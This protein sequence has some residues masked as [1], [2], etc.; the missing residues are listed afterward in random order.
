MA[1][2]VNILL[3]TY[4]GIR[5]IDELMQSLL[6]QTHPNIKIFVRDDGSNDGTI[7]KLRDYE[8][9]YANF[10]VTQGPRFGAAG[11]FMKLLNEADPTSDFYAFCDQDDVWLPRKIG[12]AVAAMEEGEKSK[13]QLYFSRLEFVDSNL[14]HLGYSRLFKKY[15]FRN[16]LVENIV[17]GCTVVLNRRARNLICEETP[18]VVLMHDWWFY[19]VVSA[20]GNLIYDKRPNIKYRQHSG[21]VI[22]EPKTYAEVLLRLLA[23]YFT[24][25]KRRIYASD[26][27]KEFYKCYASMLGPTQL[28]IL[29]DYLN[30]KDC[31]SCRITYARKMEVWKQ[32][33][34]ENAILPIRIITGRF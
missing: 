9:K 13:A 14:M 1:A 33:R 8:N 5:F 3:S 6:M 12:D 32:S 19:L 20:F 4:N 24:L 21:N 16:A 2:S 26:Q 22:G 17:S 10:M 23:P 29:K 27:A 28:Q 15:G 18:S 30:A 7:E 25:N 34:W 11:S 31:L